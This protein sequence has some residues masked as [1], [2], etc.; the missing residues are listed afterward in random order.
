MTQPVGTR[1][2]KWRR[3]GTRLTTDAGSSPLDL[4]YSYNLNRLSIAGESTH[5]TMSITEARALRDW[6]TTLDLDD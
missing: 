3:I 5:L 6:L 2:G 4:A 1:F